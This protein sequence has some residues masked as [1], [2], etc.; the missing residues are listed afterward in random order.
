MER[1][2]EFDIRQ[3]FDKKK[4]EEIAEDLADYFNWI[5]REFDPLEPEQI[6]FTNEHEM[7]VLQNFEEAARIKKFRKP[8]SM[9]PGDVF[10]VL[11]I[12]LAD[13]FAIPLTHIYTR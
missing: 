6:P 9:V 5:S 2:K 1:P 3:L 10:P 11:V 12:E 7:P 8:K 4:D 13:F